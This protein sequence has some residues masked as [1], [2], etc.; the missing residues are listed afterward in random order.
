MDLDWLVG[1]DERVRALLAH[2]VLSAERHSVSDGEGFTGEQISRGREL[3]CKMRLKMPAVIQGFDITSTWTQEVMTAWLDDWHAIIPAVKSKSDIHKPDYTLIE[4]IRWSVQEHLADLWG[5]HVR[6]PRASKMMAV[7]REKLLAWPSRE[8]TE[9][10]RFL[11]HSAHQILPPVLV[12]AKLK[13][14]HY[15]HD[16]KPEP[17]KSN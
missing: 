4:L 16:S 10:H 14:T 15:T 7:F 6:Q 11:S 8:Q 13:W 3:L 12:Q 9:L 2:T 1:L 5:D 17:R